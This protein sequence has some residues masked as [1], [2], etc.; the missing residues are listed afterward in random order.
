M[1]ERFFSWFEAKEEEPA[2]KVVV[3][4]GEDKT[5]TVFNLNRTK[6]LV[7]GIPLVIVAA[8]ALVVFF[9]PFIFLLGILMF[10]G[11]LCCMGSIIYDSFAEN[12]S[13]KSEEKDNAPE[14]EANSASTTG[15]VHKGDSLN[16]ETGEPACGH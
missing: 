12:P 2:I 15:H 13:V 6:A 5:S 14:T 4:S 3:K 16:R 8:V 11:S 9:K 7:V 1:K 10:I